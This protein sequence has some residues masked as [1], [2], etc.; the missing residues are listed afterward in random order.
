MAITSLTAQAQSPD[1]SDR[2]RV[3]SVYIASLER[4]LDL[5]Y[6]LM[7]LDSVSREAR[8]TGYRKALADANADRER[9]GKRINDLLTTNETL[10][11]NLDETTS[12][13]ETSEADLERYK[14]KTK[15]GRVIR[16]AVIGAGIWKITEIILK[17]LPL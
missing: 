5:A 13:L 4:E 3:D 14:P 1:S 10:S 11:A 6:Q 16:T 12:R 17:L 7:G 15:A 8:V 2:Q 9:M